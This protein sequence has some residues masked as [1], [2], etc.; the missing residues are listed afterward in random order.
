[1]T[2]VGAPSVPGARSYPEVFPLSVGA[3]A[4]VGTPERV[5]LVPILGPWSPSVPVPHIEVE[6]G[7]EIVTPLPD[8]NIADFDDRWAL[9][10]DDTLPTYAELARHRPHVALD[11]L[12]T[13]IGERAEA[14]TIQHRIDD[15]LVALATDWS[16]DPQLDLAAGW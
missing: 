13:P 5:P 8:G 2:L 9:I 4:S 15:I 3:S 7:A 16:L 1:M 11:E 10:R 14:F 12:A 6:V